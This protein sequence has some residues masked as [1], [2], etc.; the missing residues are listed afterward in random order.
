[1][2]YEKSSA[3]VM[4]F[5][6]QLVLYLDWILSSLVKCTSHSSLPFKAAG[7]EYHWHCIKG[8]T[9]ARASLG[10]LLSIV[11]FHSNLVNVV[12]PVG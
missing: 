10:T 3:C 4:S 11:L 9:S 7:L 8:L 12:E 2:D 1:M 5:S 6:E